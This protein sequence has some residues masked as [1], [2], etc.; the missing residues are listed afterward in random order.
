MTSNGIGR[1]ATATVVSL[2][3]GLG[4]TACSRDYTVA[5]LY[6]TASTNGTAGVV[7]GYDVDYQSGALLQLP[8]SP[9]PSGGKNP[10]TLVAAPSGKFIY[11]FNRDD[12]NVVEFAVGS[13][14]KLYAEHTYNVIGSFPTSAAIDASGKFLY[15]TSTY[16]PGFTNALPGPGDV[17]IFPI[18]SD[19][20]LGTATS[21]NVGHNPVGVVA[22]AIFCLADQSGRTYTTA[23]CTA[24]GGAAGHLTSPYVYVVDQEGGGSTNPFGVLLGFA[25]NASTGGL[26]PIATTGATTPAGGFAAGVQPSA[27]S[28]DPTGRFVYVTDFASNQLIGYTVEAGGVPVAMTNGPFTT[29]NQPINLTIDPRAKFLYV[30]NYG[31]STVGAYAIDQSTGTPA[32]S[33]GTSSAVPRTNPR[34]V[35]IEP[36]L[37]IYMYS[38][39]YTDGTV[40]GFQLDPH[41]GSLKQIQGDPFEAN[42]LPTCAVAVANGSHAT[43]VV[44]P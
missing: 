14:G 4:A 3:L 28:E 12:S 6:A 41:T 34:C 22:S 20:T 7:N 8:N 44:S 16:Q 43:Q 13:D 37:G 38:A 10:V 25:E 21:V 42:A 32:N 24:A 39:N 35:T 9:I 19:N 2:A 26:T 31:S 18:N 17:T 36:A 1:A 40:S 15:V 30:V 11:V 23:T 5:F 33:I 27:V 29:G